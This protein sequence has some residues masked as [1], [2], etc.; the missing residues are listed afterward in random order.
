MFSTTNTG[1]LA[2]GTDGG[3]VGLFL[4]MTLAS[5]GLLSSLPV[6]W[7]H[8]MSKVGAYAH[9]VSHGVVSLLTG[10]EFRRFQVTDT[11]GL[12]VTSGGNLKYITAAGYIGTIVLGAIFLARSAQQDALVVTLQ[13]LALLVALT[14]LKAGDLRT[15]AIGTLVA[16][17]LGLSGTIWPD[18]ILT[19]FLLNMMGVIMLWQGV[20]ALRTLWALSV[21]RVRVGSDAETMA[22]LTGRSALH[23]VVVFGGI[24]LVVFLLIL[25]VALS[26]GFAEGWR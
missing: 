20:V 4:L 3:G 18:S 24:S 14:T 16:A 17:T 26:P 11:G 21:S 9:E 1:L 6:V 8:H 23:W 12:C 19:H 10:G 22:K 13:V 25:G 2:A 5:V 15:A 7:R